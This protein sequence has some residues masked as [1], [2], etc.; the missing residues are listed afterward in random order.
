MKN[1]ENYVATATLTLTQSGLLAELLRRQ[2]CKM[3]ELTRCPTHRVQGR[4]FFG[5]KLTWLLA[6]AQSIVDDQRFRPGPVEETIVR[7]T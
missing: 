2:R 7:H 3:I 5:C 6:Y 4:G 1:K